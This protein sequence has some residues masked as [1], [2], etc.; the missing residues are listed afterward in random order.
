LTNPKSFALVANGLNA[1]HA[2][3]RLLELAPTLPQ[4]TNLR[5]TIVTESVTLPALGH[6]TSRRE[7]VV[8]AAADHAELFDDTDDEDFIPVVRRVV[9]AKGTSAP[10]TWA[11]RSIFELAA[12]AAKLLKVR[13]RFGDAAGINTKGGV[14]SVDLASGVTRYAGASYP[15]RWTA[16]DQERE[17]KRR[18][19]QK[20]PRP[21]KR[22]KTR[23]RKLLDIIGDDDGD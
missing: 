18:A 7:A 9:P 23:S 20:P 19:R 17:R 1:S 13:G 14:S 16:E 8:A 15:A 3:G 12:A 22:A 11:P 21:S 10:V 2:S 5:A 4:K 6:Q